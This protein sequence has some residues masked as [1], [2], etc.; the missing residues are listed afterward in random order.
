MEI[1]LHLINNEIRLFMLTFHKI[2]FSQGRDLAQFYKYNYFIQQFYIK[3]ER[4]CVRYIIQYELLSKFNL[5]N[6]KICL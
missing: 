3:K 2:N 6:V 4:A 5:L 1:L